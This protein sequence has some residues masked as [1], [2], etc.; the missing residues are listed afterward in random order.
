MQTRRLVER[1][2]SRS[3]PDFTNLPIVRMAFSEAKTIV[4][5]HR[6]E[7]ESVADALL[8]KRQ[9]SGCEIRGVA[10]GVRL[11]HLHEHLLKDVD[12]SAKDKA[13][14]KRFLK[15]LRGI[16][17][18]LEYAYSREDDFYADLF[19]VH[20]CRNAGFNVEN[21]LDVIRRQAVDFE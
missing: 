9:M 19:A 14:A 1:R 10:A 11:E 4:R 6:A 18:I 15:N 16:G 20:L 7:I 2:Y 5:R 13:K 17:A 21:G 8:A 12:A 3:I